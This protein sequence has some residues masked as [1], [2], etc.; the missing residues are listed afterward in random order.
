MIIALKVQAHPQNSSAFKVKWTNCPN[1]FTGKHTVAREGVWSAGVTTVGPGLL[2]YI[3]TP[4]EMKTGLGTALPSGCMGAIPG[5][6]IPVRTQ[7]CSRGRSLGKIIT[8]SIE[9][10][11]HPS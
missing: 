9:T 11:L 6:A 3:S 10:V 7:G 1:I 4:V 8:R 5:N 2:F